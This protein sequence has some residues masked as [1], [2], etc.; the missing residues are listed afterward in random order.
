MTADRLARAAGFE[1]KEVKTT[2]FLLTSFYRIEAPGA[3]VTVYIEGDG[4]AWLSKTR[5]ST[6]PTPRHP[7]ALELARKD[8]ETPNVVYLARPCQYTLHS[9]DPLCADASYWSNKRFSET[10][11]SS[12]NEAVDY[13]KSQSNAKELHFIGYSGG[14]A[15]AALIAARREDVKSLRTVAGNLDPEAVNRTHKVSPLSGSLN[16]MDAAQKLKGLPQRHFIGSADETIPEF[17]ARGFAAKTGGRACANVT[18]VD[19]ASHQNGWTGR[20]PEL[21]A[22]PVECK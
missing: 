16:P 18:S 1:K 7:V 21:L 14:A 4:L 12:M 9:Q 10:V 17:I 22:I 19:G 15:V 8:S 11:I 2:S 3:P 5:L 20:W 6:D 13:F